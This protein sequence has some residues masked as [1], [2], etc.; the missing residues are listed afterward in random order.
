MINQ[1][2]LKDS[3]Q[4]LIVQKKHL[5][6]TEIEDLLL[7]SDNDFYAG[8]DIEDMNYQFLDS[9]SDSKSE[10][11]EASQLQVEQNIEVINE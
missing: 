1:D 7:D 10:E 6:S 11:D 8:S 4:C 3:V 9:E 2:P 5:E